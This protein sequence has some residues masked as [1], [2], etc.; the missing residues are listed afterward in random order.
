VTVALGDVTGDGVDDLIAAPGMGGGPNVKVFDGRTGAELASFFAFGSQFQGGVTV[1]AGDTDGDGRAEIAVGAGV[2]GGPHVRVLRG[3]D[4]AAIADFMA[5]APNFLGGVRV[6]MTAD[7][8]GRA[9]LLTGAALGSPHL[10]GWNP[11]SGAEVMS[12]MA[13]RKDFLGGLYV[14]GGA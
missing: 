5:Y 6:G 12:E 10:K 13:Y 4:L 9:M 8:S 3:S 11:L 7:S 14:G 1:A 2:G